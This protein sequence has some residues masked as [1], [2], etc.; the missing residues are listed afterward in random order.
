[1][2]ACRLSANKGE[3]GNPHTG[4]NA[5][6]A[7]RRYPPR[8][9]RR[10]HDLDLARICT[11]QNRMRR[12]NQKDRRTGVL[13]RCDLRRDGLVSPLHQR[14]AHREGVRES[15]DENG[16]HPKL[17]WQRPSHDRESPRHATTPDL[18]IS[19]L[20]TPGT[21]NAPDGSAG[22]AAHR[23]GRR[24]IVV[25]PR[26]YELLGAGRATNCSGRHE[27]HPR[28]GCQPLEEARRIFRMSTSSI[29]R[30][31]PLRNNISE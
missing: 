6:D 13:L 12:R 24:S 18:V 4:L 26:T 19:N 3:S 30:H 22:H 28:V 25:G 15:R 14:S 11:D 29:L 23:L 16:V 1:M 31:G 8:F 20:S 10:S 27:L 17:R 5:T 2:L 7:I 9:R 21:L